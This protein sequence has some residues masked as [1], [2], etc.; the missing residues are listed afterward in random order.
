MN[1]STDEKRA[2][3]TFERGTTR[4][5]SHRSRSSMLAPLKPSRP[6][7]LTLAPGRVLH[8]QLNSVTSE[9][10]PWAVALSDTPPAVAPEPQDARFA[11][12]FAA[13]KRLYA[14]AGGLAGDPMSSGISMAVVAVD[15]VDG[16][17]LTRC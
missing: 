5:A 16:L 14:Q 10:A 4:T 15:R 9:N 8:A 17:C 13:A 2:K 1:T 12:S 7:P 6:S 3:G 11:F